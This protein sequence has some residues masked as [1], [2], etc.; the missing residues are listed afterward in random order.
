MIAWDFLSKVL[1]AYNKIYPPSIL[2]LS[3]SLAAFL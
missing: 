2:E 3:Y 1:A